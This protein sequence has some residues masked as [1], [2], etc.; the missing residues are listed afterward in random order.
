MLTS[1]PLDGERIAAPSGPSLPGVSVRVVDAEGRACAAGQVGG[2]E[3]HGTN[4]FSG[5]WRMPEKTREEFT[6]DGYFRTGDMG[7]LLPNGYLRIVGRARIS[8]SPAVSTSIRRRSRRR[9]TRSPA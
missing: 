4:V 5:Y 8:S 1:N 2:V 7:E 6:E 9:S 3:V